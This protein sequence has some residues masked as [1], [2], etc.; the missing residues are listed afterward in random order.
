[1]MAVRCITKISIISHR[2]SP[3][4]FDI[5]N[6][7]KSFLKQSTFELFTKCWNG[8]PFISKTSDNSMIVE[9][10]RKDYL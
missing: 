7:A 2:N 10:F 3:S 9:P 4:K 6:A 1:M 5:S 8:G